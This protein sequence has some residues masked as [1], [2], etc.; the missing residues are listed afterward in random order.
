ML[1]T[2]VYGKSNSGIRNCIFAVMCVKL[3]KNIKL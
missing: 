3:L 1:K 2:E